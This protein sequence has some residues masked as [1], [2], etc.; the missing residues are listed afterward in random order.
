MKDDDSF[1]QLMPT[2]WTDT[3]AAQP[4]VDLTYVAITA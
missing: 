4:Q 2:N 1:E 3:K